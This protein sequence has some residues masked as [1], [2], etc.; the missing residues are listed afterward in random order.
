VEVLGGGRY[1]VVVVTLRDGKVEQARSEE[2]DC[3][4]ET[5]HGLEDLADVPTVLS[6]PRADALLR[7]THLPTTQPGQVSQMVRHEAASQGPWSSEETCLGYEVYP[8][9]PGYSRVL[10]MMAR[11]DEVSEHVE[12]LRRLGL[13]PSRAEFSTVSISRLLESDTE[14]R[15]AILLR[16][17]QDLREYT[18]LSDGAPVFSRAVGASETIAEMLRKSLDLDVRKNGRTAAQAQLLIAAD[19]DE[20]ALLA[21]AQGLGFSV[22]PLSGLHPTALNGVAPLPASDLVCVGAAL[23]ATRNDI[24]GNLLPR[25]EARRQAA[26]R[27][28][29]EAKM[30]ALGGLWAGVALFAAGYQ[31]FETERGIAAT[32]TAETARLREEAGDLVAQYERLEQLAGERTRVALPLRLVLDLYERTPPDI[33]LVQL[34]Y[35][36]RGTLIL[37]GE[38]SGYPAVFT[39]LAALGKSSLLREVALTHSSKPRASKTALVEFK[40]QASVVLGGNGS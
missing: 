18:R 14:A 39:Y 37:G 6:L 15:N 23:G 33:G 1:R 30:L 2:I 19:E 21:A 38:A 7:W 34:V 3:E 12:C 32:A 13:T 35:D 40:V 27:L 17:R 4:G 10:L 11:Q 9:D 29:R 36:D 20:D 16:A 24:A 26:R 8:S 5:P 22:M 28:L 31:A 25:R